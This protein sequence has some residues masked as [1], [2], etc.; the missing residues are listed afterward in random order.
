MITPS[1]R[2]VSVAEQRT[3]A[4]HRGHLVPRQRTQSGQTKKIIY[5]EMYF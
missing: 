2:K 5:V 1:E 4:V 3:N